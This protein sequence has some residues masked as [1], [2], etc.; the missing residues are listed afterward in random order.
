MLA[1]SLRLN[2]QTSMLFLCDIQEKFAPLVHNFPTIVSKAT[3]LLE[4]AKI[5]QIPAFISEQYPSA[6]GSTV[7]EILSVVPED[8]DNYYLY[9]KKKFSQ[10]SNVNTTALCP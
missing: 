8:N 9:P 10:P 1:R 2:I 4:S 5:M 6:L 7:N 3:L